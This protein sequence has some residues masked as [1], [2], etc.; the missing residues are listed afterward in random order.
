MEIDLL[1]RRGD[2]ICPVEVKSGRNYARHSSL[3]KF[4]AK[5]GDRLGESFILY[6]KDVM[7]KDGITHLPLY[8]ASLL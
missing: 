5:F 3:D 6:A 1:V 2:R 4:R 8:M 7:K